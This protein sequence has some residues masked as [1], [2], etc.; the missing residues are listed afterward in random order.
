MKKTKFMVFG[1]IRADCHINV[2][3][4]G[5]DIERVNETKFLGVIMDHKLCWKPHIEYIKC[6]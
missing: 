6:K 5:V 2:N 3:L 1:S 4:N